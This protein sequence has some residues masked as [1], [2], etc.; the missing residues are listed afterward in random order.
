M[1]NLAKIGAAPRPELQKHVLIEAFCMLYGYKFFPRIQNL[2]YDKKI[3]LP[4]TAVVTKEVIKEE[5][6]DPKFH[7]TL[8]KAQIEKL[9]AQRADRKEDS[10]QYAVPINEDPGQ[11]TSEDPN[12]ALQANAM[13]GSNS[14]KI[15]KSNSDDSK[16]DQKPI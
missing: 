1:S 5:G 6:L 9:R 15:N 8:T 12:V 13:R 10:D 14:K 16:P 3:A 11:N 7:K 2:V 4:E